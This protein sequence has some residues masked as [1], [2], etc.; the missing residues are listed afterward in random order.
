MENFLKVINDLIYEEKKCSAKD[1]FPSLQIFLTAFEF[2][3]IQELLPGAT[4]GG[5][6]LRQ[7]LKEEEEEKER[8][9]VATENKRRTKGQNKALAAFMKTTARKNQW[10]R[11]ARVDSNCPF[12]GRYFLPRFKNNS[13]LKF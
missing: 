13:H 7:Q 6:R 2:F 3:F 8:Q 11:S 10:E 4:N 12:C 5:N 9:K 1:L